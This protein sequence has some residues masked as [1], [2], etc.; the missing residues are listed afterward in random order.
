MIEIEKISFSR[1]DK[2]ILQGFSATLD[3]GEAVLMSGANGSG[4]TTTLQLIG[5][6]LS[7]ASGEIRI[8]GRPLSEISIKD[9]AMLRSVAPA[10][11]SFT[12]AFTVEQVLEFIPKKRRA[13]HT[14]RAIAALGLTELLNR[15]VTELST[16]QQ[17]RVSLALALSQEASYYLLDEPFSGQ[18]QFF[19]QAILELITELKTTKGF[20]VISHNQEAL[21]Q[22]FDREIILAGF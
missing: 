8:A 6:L 17:E 3:I 18:D 22:Y 15:K 10:R 1:G 16:G 4:K 7:P 11:R 13:A 19:T 20:L 2:A 9:Q 5:G 12:L 14:S 21:A